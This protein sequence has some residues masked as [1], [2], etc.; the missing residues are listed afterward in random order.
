MFGH[1]LWQNLGR[2]DCITKCSYIISVDVGLGSSACH[3]VVGIWID[4]CWPL[5]DYVRTDCVGMA[6]NETEF[7]C[8]KKCW[9]SDERQPQ[10]EMYWVCRGLY[11]ILYL[12]SKPAYIS[13]FVQLKSTSS[14]NW[15]AVTDL[16]HLADCNTGGDG[17]QGWDYAKANNGLGTETEVRLITPIE[18]ECMASG[19]GLHIHPWGSV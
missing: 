18:H 1:F 14:I 11:P 3:S 10:T 16:W 13:N 19:F 8:N 6:Q 4:Q 5:L 2:Q 12:N 9:C 17:Q 15:R 7:G